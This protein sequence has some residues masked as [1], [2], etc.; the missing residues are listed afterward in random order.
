MLKRWSWILLVP[1]A[2]A[3]VSDTSDRAQPFAT[4]RGEPNADDAALSGVISIESGACLY[5]TSPDGSR[6]LV[7][8]PSRATTLDEDS[9]ILKL[10]GVPL[11]S[12][13]TV[14]FGGSGL[15][16]P[17]SEIDWEVPPASACDTTR[18]W[19]AG[20]TARINPQ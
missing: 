9:A 6:T 4:Y 8:L 5:V 11:P 7:A 1:I 13:A 17:V 3:C 15:S 19:I 14:L 10:S 18:L 20:E 16:R 2:G 12:G